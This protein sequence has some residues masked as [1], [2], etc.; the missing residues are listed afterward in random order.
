MCISCPTRCCAR[1][2][3]TS[4]RSPARTVRPG[5]SAY[6]FDEPERLRL[7]GAARG[8]A[9]HR[10]GLPAQAR[11]GRVAQRLGAGLRRP[12]DPGCVPVGHVLPRARVARLRARGARRRASGS[13]RRTCRSAGTTRATRCW[14]RCGACWPTPASRWSATAATGRCPGAHTGPG[15]IGAVLARHP[16]PDAGGRPPGHARVRASSSTWPARI[17]GCTWTPRWRSPTSPRRCAVPA[18]AA[19]APA[20]PGRP[21]RARLRLP[22]H[23]LP[24]RTPIE[25][26]A[27]LDLGDDW[28]RAV[29]HDNGVRLLGVD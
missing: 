6:R 15:P 7:A 18:G 4:T 26:L 3:R 11:H 28:L 21:G 25:A 19:P 22:Q 14:T 10:A 16:R 23:P 24:V 17:R 9:L 2:G 1:C 12:G 13:S 27:R 29:L 20:R 5:R 8:G